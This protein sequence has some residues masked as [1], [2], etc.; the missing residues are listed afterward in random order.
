VVET[1]NELKLDAPFVVFVVPSDKFDA[2]P[3]QAY[4]DDDGNIHQRPG[5]VGDCVQFALSVPL[6]A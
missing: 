4:L 1:L 6:G 3:K 2:F 5:K